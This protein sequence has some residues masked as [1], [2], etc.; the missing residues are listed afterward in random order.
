MSSFNNHRLNKNEPIGS[1]ITDSF[2]AVGGFGQLLF[3][4][5]IL[6]LFGGFVKKIPTFCPQGY[7][8]RHKKGHLSCLFWLN[9]FANN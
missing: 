7:H 5:Y 2:V 6:L 8:S 9:Q 1:F 3:I 4:Y